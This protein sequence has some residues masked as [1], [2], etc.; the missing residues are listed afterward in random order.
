MTGGPP[1]VLEVSDETAFR[2]LLALFVL[3]V[4][5]N[6]ELAGTDPAVART[7]R[8]YVETWSGP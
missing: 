4:R 6:P 1:A 7:F 3:F 2:D 8:A 5:R